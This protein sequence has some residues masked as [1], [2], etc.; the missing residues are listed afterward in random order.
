MSESLRLAAKDNAKSKYRRQD[1]TELARL[2][3]DNAN[4]DA[5]YIAWAQSATFNEE[6]LG[7]SVQ[8]HRPRFEDGDRDDDEEGGGSGD[9]EQNE[10]DEAERE[11]R[12]REY[13]KGPHSD[14]PAAA[15]T[16]PGSN[17]FEPGVGMQQV[18]LPTFSG[19]ATTTAGASHLGALTTWASADVDGRKLA[20]VYATVRTTPKQL[21]TAAGSVF[22][23]PSK[24][25]VSNKFR[26][27]D[28]DATVQGTA[29]SAKASSDTVIVAGAV[30]VSFVNNTPVQIGVRAVTKGKDGG[31]APIASL[32]QEIGADGE[33]YFA[34]LQPQE[35]SDVPVPVAILKSIETSKV[36]LTYGDLTRD[37]LVAQRND[38][39]AKALRSDHQYDFERAGKNPE[40]YTIVSE[41]S[42]AAGRHAE[43]YRHL[44][45]ALKVEPFLVEGT[46]YF[47]K[48]NVDQ[49]IKQLLR[50]IENAPRFDRSQFALQFVQ[51]NARSGAS[52]ADASSKLVALE[53]I[54]A[55]AVYNVNVTLALAFN[56]HD[57][58]TSSST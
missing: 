15:I 50:A 26:N 5:E 31:H 45:R 13:E 11:L 2:H 21:A 40:D 46:K 51:S 9:D 4:L 32:N 22:P 39:A 20:L 12:E 3:E 14:N 58:K 33:P 35:S 6:V 52:G 1:N 42:S 23:V 53:G 36:L 29:T 38:A 30:R 24:V 27:N 49:A 56:H 8:S 10:V 18:T 57:K 47:L 55:T 37:I 19:A 17:K 7:V 43:V 25:F 34:V 54:D 48:S 28:F 41:K 16:H 44:T